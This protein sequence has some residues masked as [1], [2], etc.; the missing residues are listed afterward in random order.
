VADICE[1]G[2]KLSGY[3]KVG[4]REIPSLTELL[5]AL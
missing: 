1:Y 2:N 4:D 3:I 5:L